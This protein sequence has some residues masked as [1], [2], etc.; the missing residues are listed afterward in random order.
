MAYPKRSVLSLAKI[1]ESRFLSRILPLNAIFLV[2]AV[3]W[4][5]NALR[6]SVG[7]EVAIGHVERL[8][9]G[10]KS[11][12][13]FNMNTCDFYHVYYAFKPVGRSERKEMRGVDSA[14]FVTLREGQELPVRYLREDPSLHEIGPEPLKGK[15]TWMVAGTIL[16]SCFSLVVMLPRLHAARAIIWLR[17][18]GDQRTA[19]VL[20]YEGSGSSTVAHWRD[21][22][23]VAGKTAPHSPSELPEVGAE[24]TIYGDPMGRQ[25]SL[26]EGDVGSR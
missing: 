15:A 23:G 8:E 19:T 22:T 4:S 5:A 3:A 16:F 11:C 17:D 25:P 14:V 2:I 6:L 21:S 26:W 10:S 9:R 7:G 24:I 1:E 13:K 18:K 20:R 12:G